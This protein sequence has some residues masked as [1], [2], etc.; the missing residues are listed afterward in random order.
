VEPAESQANQR[1]EGKRFDIADGAMVAVVTVWA[2]NNIIVKNALDQIDPLSYVF[3]RFAIVVIA[4]FAWLKWRKVPLAIRREDVPLFLFTGFT[5]YAVYNMLFTV[6]LD[7]TSAFSTAV[8][9]SIGPIITILFAAIIGMERIRSK[10]W[11][12]VA[13]SAIG[14]TIFV[15]E[16]LSGGEPV[17]GD[18]LSVVAAVCFAAYSLA[19]QPLVKRYGS[20]TVTAWSALI[21]LLFA[22]PITLPAVVDQDWGSIDL[23]GWASLF[24][25]ALLSMLVAYT[26]WAWAIERRGVAKTVPFMYLIPILSGVFSAVVLNESF[27]ALKL[28]GGTLVLTGVALARRSSSRHPVSEPVIA[29]TPVAAESRG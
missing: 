21:G 14:V 8:L 15:G 11:L 26:I 9:V 24:Y 2:A 23:A 22:I 5:G 6:A 28:I 3:G 7:H 18:A 10:Q 20:P 12:G 17:I 25:S 1:N 19:T 13:V 4:L 29:A 16:K 27:G